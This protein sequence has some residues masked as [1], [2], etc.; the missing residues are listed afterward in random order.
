MS[1]AAAYMRPVHD[2]QRP[3][4]P[5]LPPTRHETA[6]DALCVLWDQLEAMG[7]DEAQRFLTGP[8]AAF[9]L[10]LDVPAVLAA[11]QR[12]RARREARR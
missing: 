6:T 11:L 1:T 12:D 3:A 4:L 8:A 9:L 10:G 7:P 2:S 5:V